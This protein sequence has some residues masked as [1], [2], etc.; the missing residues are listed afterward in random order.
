[1]A[2]A[3]ALA[4]NLDV[5]LRHAAAQQLLPIRLPEIEVHMAVCLVQQQFLRVGERR[6]KPCRDLPTDLVTARTDGGADADEY[7]ARLRAERLRHARERLRRN[8]LNRSL[9]AAV[10]YADG[11]AKKVKKLTT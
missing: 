11:T 5:F 1:M 8:R 9:P 4:R 3:G 7:V 10:R 2:A 6:A